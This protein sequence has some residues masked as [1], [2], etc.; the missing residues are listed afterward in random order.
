MAGQLRVDEVANPTPWTV[1]VRVLPTRASRWLGAAYGLLLPPKKSYSQYGEDL[2]VGAFFAALGRSA[3]TYVD[4]GAFHPKWL[5]NT[6][7]L[8]KSGWSG[9]VVD[10]DPGKVEL[11]VRRRGGERCHGIT[12]AVDQ[13]SGASVTSYRFNRL[14]SEIDT[15]SEPDAR[16]TA[17]RTGIGYRPVNTPTVTV[18]EVL[19]ATTARFGPMIDFLNIDIE[20]LDELVLAGMNFRRFRPTVVCFESNEHFGGTPDTVALL[21]SLGYWHLAT[22]GG[23]Q[24]YADEDAAQ[25]ATTR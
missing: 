10:I 16:N 6:Y 9:T 4:I 23:S 12:A 14:W 19:E 11:C 3:G 8:A 24:I 13:R 15:L 17:R 2:I 22:V 21:T 18:N 7:L 1:A 20:G 5:S 25:R